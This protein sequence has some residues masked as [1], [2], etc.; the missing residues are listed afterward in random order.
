MS[1]IACAMALLASASLARAEVDPKVVEAL[2]YVRD[3]PDGGA[4]WEFVRKDP[5]PI[6][7]ARLLPGVEGRYIKAADGRGWVELNE[8]LRNEP[9]PRVGK[10]LYHQY[11]H[12]LQDRAPQLVAPD[13]MDTLDGYVVAMRQL[14]EEV[15]PNGPFPDAPAE[16][17]REFGFQVSIDGGRGG[18][19]RR[20]SLVISGGR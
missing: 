20:F 1:P 17:R 2:A 6:V 9:G 14:R 5:I 15:R 8:R 12:R 16:V 18:R 10:A 7:F 3:A 19:R 4:M 13:E 11:L